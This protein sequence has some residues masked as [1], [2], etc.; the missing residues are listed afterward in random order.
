V[1]DFKFDKVT[2]SF[3]GEAGQPAV[4]PD[5]EYVAFLSSG[6]LPQPPTILESVCDFIP[7]SKYKSA[8]AA[9]RS[10]VVLFDMKRKREVNR[11]IVGDAGTEVTNLRWWE[12]EA[13]SVLPQTSS[14]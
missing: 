6:E 1:T 9:N 12:W 11:L 5:G 13:D 8:N 4:S 7:C 10:Y 14:D 3:K 2:A